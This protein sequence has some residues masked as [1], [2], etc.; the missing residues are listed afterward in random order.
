MTAMMDRTLQTL[1][2]WQGNPVCREV[3][4]RFT[5]LA[6][7]KNITYHDY[8]TV[9]PA[10]V[11]QVRWCAAKSIAAAVALSRGT[12]PFT[13][14]LLARTALVCCWNST[15]TTRLL[16]LW[17]GLAVTIVLSLFGRCHECICVFAMKMAR[18][19]RQVDLRQSTGN[20]SR[21]D[22]IDPDKYLFGG[23]FALRQC[24]KGMDGFA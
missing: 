20:C 11:L 6:Y 5:V 16:V 4:Y 19:L 17:S 7:I 3:E 18:F 1:L 21:Q 13:L 14:T 2:A 24:S 22:M 12:G 10:E 23:R 15:R 8:G 9:D